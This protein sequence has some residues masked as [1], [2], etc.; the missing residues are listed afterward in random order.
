VLIV[1]VVRRNDNASHALVL[2]LCVCFFS[3]SL[4]IQIEP[5]KKK[6]KRVD[7]PTEEMIIMIADRKE[8]VVLLLYSLILRKLI[9]D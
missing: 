2:E 5:K 9:N 3:H 1:I 7:K 8:K 6:K 4:L